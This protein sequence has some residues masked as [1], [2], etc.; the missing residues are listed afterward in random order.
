MS[1][2]NER[3]EKLKKLRAAR[4]GIQL[5]ND[6]EDD[7]LYDE[8]DEHEYRSRKRQELLRDDFVV[9]DDGLGY[10]D[11]GVEEDQEDYSE[12]ELD[13]QGEESAI[14]KKKSTKKQKDKNSIGNLLRVQQN[15]E[16]LSGRAA[17]LKTKNVAIDEFD[18]ILGE[19]DNDVVV[20]VKPNLRMKLPSSPTRPSNKPNPSSKIGHSAS[21]RR[22]DNDSSYNND[23][24]LDSSPLKSRKVDDQ[25]YMNELMKNLENS[26]MS[27]R[28]VSSL[29]VTQAEKIVE[30]DDSDDEIIFGRRTLRSVAATRQININ[31]SSNAPSSP[32]VT[33]PSTPA[34]SRKADLRKGLNSSPEPLT[35]GR[36]RCEKDQV[37]DPSSGNFKMFWLDYCEV[38]NSLVLFGKIKTNDNK[39]VSGMVQIKGLCRELYFL[40]L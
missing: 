15:K 28:S 17:Q 18:D 29:R 31:S 1:G 6:E 35:I 3:L 8:I 32:F 4:N 39:L 26:P 2:Q 40:P 25:D 37:V 11:R 7:R 22:I 10:V 30:D 24:Q 34:I 21:K 5:P 38:D 13:E 27:K 23:I 16:I 20:K 33:A 19:F 12:E 36:A 9:D 14:E